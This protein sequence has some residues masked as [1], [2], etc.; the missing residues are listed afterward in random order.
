[1]REKLPF[2][3]RPCLRRS[4]R[5][6]GASNGKTEVI[7]LSLARKR[8]PPLRLRVRN[9]MRNCRPDHYIL[10]IATLCI[11]S[12]DVFH[13]HTYTNTR[14]RA[15]RT[16]THILGHML[17]P[18]ER[19]GVRRYYMVIHSWYTSRVRSH[20]W[21]S[22]AAIRAVLSYEGRQVSWSVNIFSLLVLETTRHPG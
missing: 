19:H 7:R 3:L 22:S 10:Y 8:I 13:A 1:M 12:L 21:F 5:R 4:F 18:N 15:P 2:R 9:V 17:H 20:V 11:Q 6:R 14:A 16:N